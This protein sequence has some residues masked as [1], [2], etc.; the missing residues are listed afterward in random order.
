[1]HRQQ[2]RVYH[3]DTALMVDDHD[4]VG[5][6]IEQILMIMI[7]FQIHS[8]PSANADESSEPGMKS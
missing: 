5:N 3:A 7:V 2:S 8:T 4:R 1:V 6:A